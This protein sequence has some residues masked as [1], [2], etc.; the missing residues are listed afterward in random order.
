M[1]ARRIEKVDDTG[2][3]VAQR[4]FDATDR[5]LV[6]VIT[7]ASAG[8]GRASAQA[9]VE[10]GSSIGPGGAGPRRSASRATRPGPVSFLRLTCEM[11]A[12]SLPDDPCCS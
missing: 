7:G 11:L 9:F 4:E 3:D 12:A 1:G 10:L 5:L 6:V 8:V 2:G